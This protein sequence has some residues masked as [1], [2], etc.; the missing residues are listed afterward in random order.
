M[1]IIMNRWYIQFNEFNM[2]L[3]QHPVY[4][5]L[6]MIGVLSIVSITI[7]TTMR[8]MREF[9]ITYAI[10]GIM[11]FVFVVDYIYGMTHADMLAKSLSK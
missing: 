8:P 7:F 9:K 10:F 11:C 4:C 2:F 3:F 5:I 6:F 1:K